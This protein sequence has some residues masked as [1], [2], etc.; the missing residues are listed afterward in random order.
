MMH[1]IRVDGETLAHEIE[2]LARN[3]WGICR[4]VGQTIAY[5]GRRWDLR[6]L[7]LYALYSGVGTSR[8]RPA[9]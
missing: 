5:R 7:L 2:A 3:C 9:S 8:D 1:G 4:F 6:S